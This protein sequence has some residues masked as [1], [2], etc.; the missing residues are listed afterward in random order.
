MKYTAGLLSIIFILFPFATNAQG[1]A[2][3]PS[4]GL[5]PNPQSFGM[6]MSGV[7][8][9]T[10]DPLGFYF[11]P[12][13]LGYSSQSNNLA[14]QFYTNKVSWMPGLYYYTTSYNNT[15]ITAGYNLEIY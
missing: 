5:N 3:L 4:L 14:I 8:L 13:I 9:P 10:N 7:S 11:N 6:G 1:Y 15:G 2:A 12:A